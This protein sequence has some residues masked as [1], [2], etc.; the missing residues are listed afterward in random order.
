MFTYPKQKMRHKM[1]ASFYFGYSNGATYC[2][3]PHRMGVC[4][5]W[6]RNWFVLENGFEP[7][8]PLYD[9]NGLGC[10]DSSIRMLF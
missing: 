1:T 5:F 10:A 4:P 9:D 3:Q 7:K 6:M 8:N 2:F